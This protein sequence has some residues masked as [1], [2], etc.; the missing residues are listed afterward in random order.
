MLRGEE[1]H[2]EKRLDFLRAEGADRVQKT[3]S[4]F[5]QGGSKGKRRR[6]EIKLE[7]RG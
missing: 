2:K 4:S 3:E 7:R 5:L 6:L 1:G